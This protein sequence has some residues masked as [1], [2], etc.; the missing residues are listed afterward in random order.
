LHREVL[1]SKKEELTMNC[2][3]LSS[4]HNALKV[5]NPNMIRLISYI[6]RTQESKYAYEFFLVI[7]KGYKNTCS[8]KLLSQKF[9]W[10]SASHKNNFL[11]TL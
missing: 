10:S 6:A 5:N 3:T 8:Y 4:Y 2:K 7:L 1:G 11:Y 9:S